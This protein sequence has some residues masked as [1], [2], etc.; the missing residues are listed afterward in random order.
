[1]GGTIVVRGAEMVD[2]T[3]MQDTILTRATRMARA[4]GARVDWH[5]NWLVLASSAYF[6]R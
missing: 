1:M 2:N 5:A 6:P 4:V 3:V